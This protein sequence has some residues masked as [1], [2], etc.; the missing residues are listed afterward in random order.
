MPCP[1]CGAALRVPPGARRRLGPLGSIVVGSLAA[2]AVSHLHLDHTGGLRHL[3]GRVPV[4]VQE[5]ELRF[6]TG[7]ARREDGYVR[8]D[9]ELP[10]LDWR[11]LDGDG[12]IAPGVDAVFTPGH[13]PGHMSYRVRTARGTWL[14]AVDAIDLRRGVDEPRGRCHDVL[15]PAEAAGGGREREERRIGGAVDAAAG[16]GEAVGTGI[17]V[18]EAVPPDQATALEVE[19]VDVAPH[20]LEVDAAAVD[21]RR[22]RHRA[23]VALLHEPWSMRCYPRRRNRRSG[24]R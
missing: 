3:A 9:Y 23:R 11:T 22:R 2:A 15:C 5:R 10:G 20:V 21:D 18:S 24:R 14:F 17:R 16:D 8:E 7:R 1:A 6:A 12:E 13:T 4:T 19:G